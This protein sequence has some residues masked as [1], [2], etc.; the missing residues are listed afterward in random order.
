MKITDDKMLKEIQ[1]EFHAKFPNLK[2]EFYSIPHGVG[3][4]STEHRHIPSAQTIG[5][6]RTIHTEGELS[7]NGHL[8]VSTLEAAFTNKYGL[9][10]QVFRRSSGDEWLQ[11]TST[12]HWTLTQQNEHG[13]R[14]LSES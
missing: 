10:V 3:E 13:A 12:D 6:V 9:N 1:D 7:I 8:K 11:T 14:H 5:T 2:I 4:G